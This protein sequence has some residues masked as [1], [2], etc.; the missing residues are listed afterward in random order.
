[1][2]KHPLHEKAIKLA[3]TYIES[4]RNLIEVLS[5]IDQYKIWRSLGHASFFE[6]VVQGLKLSEAQAYTLTAVTRKC[7]QI[8]ELKKAIL[9]KKISISNAKRILPVLNQENSSGWLSKAQTLST[10]KLEREVA[11][12]NPRVA[13]H[14]SIK[15]ISNDLSKMTL[16][17]GVATENLI[18]RAQ[19]LLAAQ[20]RQNLSLEDALKL[21]AELTIQK[22]DK[23]EKAKRNAKKGNAIQ[24]IES[25]RRIPDQ[26]KH[27]VIL[28]DDGKCQAVLPNGERCN[29]SRFIEL[30]HK[31][32]YSKGGI[33]HVNNL[34]TLC[35][36]H[37]KF[38][39]QHKTHF[40]TIA[41]L[42][43]PKDFAT[44]VQTK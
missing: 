24:F 33:H 11:S 28:R 1:M 38:F 43:V 27:Q 29:Q 39:H 17:V 9:A 22:L 14:E 15:P 19:D 20:K 18:K 30:H 37:H 13:I 23:L 4:E 21:M 36:V 31:I 40:E 10:R 25:K 35:S 5:Q 6:Y 12:V 3:N 32:P 44:P 8:P 16:C 41:R 42:K 7:E 34:L 26:I 2:M